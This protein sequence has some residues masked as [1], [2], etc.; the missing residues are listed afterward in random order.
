MDDPFDEAIDILASVI[1]QSDTGIEESNLEHLRRSITLVPGCDSAIAEFNNLPDQ[2]AN[3]ASRVRQ[4]V[5]LAWALEHPC[6]GG[7]QCN[8]FFMEDGTCVDPRCPNRESPDPDLPGTSVPTT[9]VPGTSVTG[10]SATG[11]HAPGVFSPI[12]R[13][14]KPK[15]AIK[16]RIKTCQHRWRKEEVDAGGKKRCCVCQHRLQYLWHCATCEARLCTQCRFS[17][18]FST[19]R[20]T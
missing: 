19:P 3:I 18:A 8:L 13:P 6:Q 16:D 10:S 4:T 7:Q 11:S 20:W 17:N 9:S 12:T 1:E 2:L 5:S 14:L 15:S